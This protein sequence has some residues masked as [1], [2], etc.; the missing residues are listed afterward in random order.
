VKNEVRPAALDRARAKKAGL[1]DRLYLTLRGRQR[2]R[3]PLAGL[4]ALL[5]LALWI[6]M[7]SVPAALL[8]DRST[9]S[10]LVL[11]RH[12]EP[13]YEALSGDGTRSV[14]L[15]ADTLPPLLVAA[16]VAAEDRRFWS[17]P[18]VDP[19]AIL[20]AVK[21]N[22]L[23]RALVEGGSTI[24]QQTAKLLLNRRNPKRSRG[25]TAKVQEAVLAL[26]LEHRFSKR[27]ILAIYLNLAGYGNQ[28]AGVER[29][30]GAY[31]GSPVSMLT[32]A[33]AAF[34]AGL[35]QRPSRFNPWRSFDVALS[36]QRVVLTRMEAAG[37][38]T[39]DQSREAR[40]ETLTLAPAGSPFGAP[41]FVEMVLEGSDENR[42]A[43]INTTLDRSLQNEVAGIIASH[44]P[45]L[46]KHG[47][48]NVAV[49]VL[50]NAH[51]Q[52]LAWEGSGNYDDDVGGG[53]INGPVTL[54]QPGS[55]L[56]PFTYALA[57]E[58]GYTPASVLAD[59]PSSFPT[60]DEGIVYSPRNYDGRFRG[61]LLARAALAGSENVPAVALASEVG[62]PHLLRF[63]G[64]A[65]LT[66]F[67]KTAAHYGLGL[68]LGN[69]EVRLDELTA[70]YSVFA[71]GGERIQPTWLLDEER[72]EAKRIVSQRTAF[73]I[74]DILSDA[75]AREYV[76]GRGGSL[77]F[78]FPVAVKTGTS[79]A[80]HDNWT[81][82]Y[83]KHVTVGVWVGNFDRT[84]LRNSSGITGAAPIFHAVMLAAE[85][86]VA[87]DLA[88]P[89]AE[90][91]VDVSSN[92]IEREI[93]A[94]SGLSANRWCPTRRYEWT[95]AE[96]AQLPCSWHH[97][98]D[99]R[100]LTI[101][102]VEYRAWVGEGEGAVRV[103]EGA[104]GGRVGAVGARERAD[105][106][107]AGAVGSG[108]GAVGREAV[109]D[110]EGAASEL[111]IVSP[112]SGAT[113]LIDPTLRRE[114]QTLPL[115]AVTSS[116]RPI[117]WSVNGQ[118]V[119]KATPPAKIEWRLTP[120]RHEITARDATGRIATTQITV[121]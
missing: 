112:P 83:S 59:V 82:G 90:R 92:T 66:T 46:R 30:S 47:A 3:L 25:W 29:A 109:G 18:G 108:E 45:L 52:W 93:C 17:H 107:S 103:H 36:R 57:F 115:R 28:I 33:Q 63:L 114:F 73:W 91:I 43:R 85:K 40:E 21:T 4:A 105:R 88:A 39:P 70:A 23:E 87:G 69:A 101:W 34:L 74:T 12:G 71:R 58:Q 51:G 94:L 80:Y 14:K 62:I 15:T 53:R 84:P 19:I 89:A 121:R 35:P 102:P 118:P 49:V 5:L 65:G 64:R 31:F 96:R 54:R 24:S 16:T 119:G 61:P 38:L 95:A 44:K 56:K 22:L 48:A 37:A 41:H 8:D 68:T 110:R 7:G 111:S 77:E 26:R 50:D 27:E 116:H 76:F 60:A 2:W 55:A 100:L 81:I 11:D 97:V 113:Y 9:A 67:D 6:R 117:E 72:S 106:E 86:R 79:Q 98:S 104:I 10:T 13:L 99:G 120:G 78:P 75:E 1:Y 42:P 32:P 20:R